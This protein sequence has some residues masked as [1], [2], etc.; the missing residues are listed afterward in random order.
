MQ[1]S[2]RGSASSASVAGANGSSLWRRLQALQPTLD[3]TTAHILH[4]TPTPS[5][6]TYSFVVVP[7]PVPAATSTFERHVASLLSHVPHPAFMTCTSYSPYFSSAAAAAAAA[8]GSI[9]PADASD[10]AEVS[11][12]QQALA[13]LNAQLP[14][15]AGLVL[16]ITATRTTTTPNAADEYTR[17]LVR[18]GGGGGPPSTLTG[19]SE[20]GIR[21]VMRD[22]THRTV[23][24]S[25]TNATTAPA[26]C[27][28]AGL[29]VLR[30]DD[31]GYTRRRHPAAATAAAHGSGAQ[32]LP[33]FYPTTAASA[34]ADSAFSHLPNPYSTFADG[35]ALLRFVVS[36]QAAPPGDA[37]VADL[38][39]FTGGYAQGHVLDRVWDDTEAAPKARGD[40]SAQHASTTGVP[41]SHQTDSSLAFLARL[42]KLYADTE[43]TL[44]LAQGPPHAPH[45]ATVE[46]CRA[47]ADALLVRLDAVR[48]LWLTPSHYSAEA[49]AA[50]TRQLIEEKVLLW[51]GSEALNGGSGGGGGARVIVTQMLTSADEFAG[52]VDD[53]QR[54]LHDV[55]CN[56]K[57]ARQEDGAALVLVPGLMAPLRGEQFV[58]ATLLLKVIPSAPVRDALDVYEAALKSACSH[59]DDA[60]DR[61][62][63]DAESAAVRLFQQAKEAAEVAFQRAV[64]DFTVAVARSLYARGYTHV[65]FSAFQY[66]CGEAVGRVVARLPH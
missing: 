56:G 8:A 26:S 57:S 21:A 37:T 22:F 16:T 7:P 14:V 28:N 2:T 60:S 36:E 53:V 48:Q 12:T 41:L 27:R 3:L 19:A 35:A 46:T 66:G 43:A 17:H 38:C 62:A 54:A 25:P 18:T 51:K 40:V 1:A 31:G 39:L 49:R 50:C 63:P 55:I 29:M 42:E 23:T 47:I 11:A 24:L 61:V 15:D 32:Q 9:H 45:A 33:L 44:R 6:M 65:N 59:L 20:D 4:P 5:S 64:E 58:R 34:D 10:V 52:Y 13:F 30:G